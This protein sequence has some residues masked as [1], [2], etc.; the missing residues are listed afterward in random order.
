MQLYVAEEWQGGSGLYYVGCVKDLGNNSDNW[1]HLLKIFDVDVDN[2]V[3]ILIDDFHVDY[4]KYCIE[5]DVLIYH[6]KSL[7]A[8]RKFK[9]AVNKKARDKRYMI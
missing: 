4:L 9:N 8:A 3:K 1:A 7:S 5:T 6:W 2:L